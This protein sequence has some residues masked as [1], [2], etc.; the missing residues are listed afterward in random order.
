MPEVYIAGAD[1]IR[2][3]RHPD[4]SPF[5]LA[6]EASLLALDDCGLTIRDIEAAITQSIPRCTTPGVEPYVERVGAAPSFKRTR[7][8]RW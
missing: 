3:G 5:Q 4:R 8:A 2:F 1:M 6:A 7:K